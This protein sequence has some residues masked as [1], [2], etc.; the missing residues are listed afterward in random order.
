[1]NLDVSSKAIPVPNLEKLQVLEGYYAWRRGQAA[2][3]P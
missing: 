3:K 1:M 2:A